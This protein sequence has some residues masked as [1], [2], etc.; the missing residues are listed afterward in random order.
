MEKLLKLIPGQNQD[1]ENQKLQRKLDRW[2][3]GLDKIVYEML[4]QD[5]DPV[6]YLRQY[7]KSLGRGKSLWKSFKTF[8]GASQ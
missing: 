1:E 4:S 8:F 3:E 7:T 5:V 2:S 6:F